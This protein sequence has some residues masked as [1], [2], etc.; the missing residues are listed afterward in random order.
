[1]EADEVAKFIDSQKRL[2]NQRTF[3]TTF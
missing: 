3:S 1:M 2:V